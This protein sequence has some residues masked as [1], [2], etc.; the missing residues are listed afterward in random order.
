MKKALC[1]ID[2]VDIKQKITSG[3]FTV[4][5]N[6]MNELLLEDTQTGEA[7]KIFKL[8]ESYSKHKRGKWNP[9]WEYTSTSIDHP[10][11]GREA[12]S[13]SECGWTTDERHD[14]CTCG[15]DMRESK[16]FNSELTELLE[17]L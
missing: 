4:K 6:F 17:V 3:R 12:W 2:I 9:V 11:E 13:C 10:M 16:K 5:I 15:A 7:V 8:P 14:W 1:S